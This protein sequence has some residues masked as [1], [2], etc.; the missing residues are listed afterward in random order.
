L[1]ISS[2][3]QAEADSSKLSH[4]ALQPLHDEIPDGPWT[5]RNTLTLKCMQQSHP[6][7]RV[8]ET[9][10]LFT[11]HHFHAR[12]ALKKSSR[13]LRIRKDRCI[14]TDSEKDSQEKAVKF[15]E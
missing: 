9:L 14:V 13:I 3:L 15:R 1:N 8:A 10:T 12:V 2:S 4:Q 7:Y 6:P 5:N 11:C